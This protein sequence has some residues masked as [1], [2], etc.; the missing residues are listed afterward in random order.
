VVQ[1]G[2]VLVLPVAAAG[3]ILEAGLLVVLVC[4]AGVLLWGGIR[5]HGCFRPAVPVGGAMVLW[6]S[7]LTPWVPGGAKALLIA[8]G[9]ALSFWGLSWSRALV[10]ACGCDECTAAG[11]TSTSAHA[12]T[13]ASDRS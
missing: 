7:A 13:R 1:P 10:S 9:G 6:L 4:G 8:G 11:S 3:E 5:R 12:P 2:L